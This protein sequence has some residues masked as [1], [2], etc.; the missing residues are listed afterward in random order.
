MCW[1][2]DINKKHSFLTGKS[3][4]KYCK[5]GAW[6]EPCSWFKDDFLYSLLAERKG[7]MKGNTPV[8]LLIRTLIL[9][10]NILFT[11]PYLSP[12]IW[13]LNAIMLGINTSTYGFW[14]DIKIQSIACINITCNKHKHEIWN[15]MMP[16]YP[17][18][19]APLWLKEAHKYLSFDLLLLGVSDFSLQDKGA[20]T[21]PG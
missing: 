16:H 9:L 18:S 6:W 13:P 1:V 4:S 20:Y 2:N 7:K 14:R 15:Y 19:M 10:T 11:W 5:N 3:S 17:C 21:D 12:N 8:S